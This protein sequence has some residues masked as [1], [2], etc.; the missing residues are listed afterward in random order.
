DAVAS[1]LYLDYSREE[2]QWIPNKYGERENLEAIGFLKQLNETVYEHFPNVLMIAEESTAWPS[3]SRPTYLGGL[4][5]NLKWNMG[6]MND[7]LEYMKNDPIHRKFHHN[8]ITFSLW[9]AFTE[10][11]VL[12]LSHDE[13]VH[14]KASLLSKMPGDRWQMFANLRLAYCYMYGHPGKKLLFM[15]GEFGQW[16]EWNVKQSLDWHLL[17]FEPH[18]KLRQFVRDLNAMYKQNPALWELDFTPE[19]FQWIDFQDAESSIVSFLRR[20]KKSKDFLLFICNFTPVPRFDYRLGVPEKGF[21][22]ELLNS[23]AESYGG[24]NLG[25]WGGV[26]AQAIPYHAY[27][28]S[29]EVAVPPLAAVVFKLHTKR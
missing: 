2:G 12:V 19:G 4:G 22:Q 15:G 24:S 11:F 8:K 21:Y 25:N 7:F 5:F 9:Y 13:V 17:E 10:N 14:G 16:N 1:M 27:E 20:G 29:I 18:R 28:Y 3:V 6:W 26:E 23:D